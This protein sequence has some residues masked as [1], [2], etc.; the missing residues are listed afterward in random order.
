MFFLDSYALIE[1][2]KGTP[3][4]L[5]SR[6]EAEI[7][8]RT[9]LLE[10]YSILTQ[11]NE[12]SL[13]NACFAALRGNAMEL[14]LDLIPTIARFRLRTLGA[15]GRRFSYVDACGYVYARGNG[16]AFLTGAYELEGFPAV[17]FVR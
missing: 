14:E 17:T 6:D 8:S 5:P 9:D 7:T 10:A 3:N 15:T 4:N 16:Y 1:M 13:A 11:L 2:A 12:E